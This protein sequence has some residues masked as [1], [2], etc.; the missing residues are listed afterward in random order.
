MFR[1][2]RSKH[3]GPSGPLSPE[4]V[5]EARLESVRARAN[6]LKAECAFFDALAA[7]L[8]AVFAGYI[9]GRVFPGAT[10]ITPLLACAVIAFIA[11]RTFVASRRWTGRDGA[12]ALIDGEMNLKQR[13]VTFGEYA[14]QRVKPRLFERLADDIVAELGPD[15]IRRI[16]PHRTPPSA[17]VALAIALALLLDAA[18]TLTGMIRRTAPEVEKREERASR[19]EEKAGQ[20]ST[21]TPTPTPT[22]DGEGGGGT[23]QKKETPTPGYGEQQQ[24]AQMR[25]ELRQM[26]QDI[27]RQL[28]RAEQGGE[29]EIPNPKSKIPKKGENQGKKGGQAKDSQEGKSGEK[30]SGGGKEGQQNPESP[31]AS[32]AAAGRQTPNPKEAG[33]EREKNTQSGAGGTEKQ[34]SAAGGSQE[35]GADGK[36]AGGEK[37]GGKAGDE[38]RGG[39]G[40]IP[41]PKS[42]IPK[43]GEKQGEK[44]K[45]PA[46]DSKDGKGGKKQG[47]EQSDAGDQGQGGINPLQDLGLSAGDRSPGGG[48]AESLSSGGGGA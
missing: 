13:L 37:G 21:P 36:S 35:K 11:F 31:G 8:A 34:A 5:I 41:N 18:L 17:Y 29:G 22:P 47:G 38:Q 24:M 44:G 46:K 16:L 28:D 9:L 40:E 12:A 48:G 43:K 14:S 39:E 27:S 2:A 20:E 3:P 15:R 25:Q 23:A 10:A 19:E 32:S 6:L 1:F 42:Q 45:E 4:A 7:L 33:G 30:S 26:M